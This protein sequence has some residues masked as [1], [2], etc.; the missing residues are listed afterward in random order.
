MT[1]SRPL[2]RAG[3]RARTLG[4]LDDRPS[5]HFLLLDPATPTMWRVPLS[6]D[7]NEILK[8]QFSKNG[9]SYFNIWHLVW[10]G[11]PI[12]LHQLLFNQQ[13]CCR[14]SS[15][16]KKDT[17]LNKYWFYKNR[18]IIWC[19]MILKLLIVKLK[20]KCQKISIWTYPSITAKGQLITEWNF[21][22][23]K[24]PKKQTWF[25]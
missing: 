19:F 9:H 5:W 6:P 11:L 12:L 7:K 2:D 8:F 20:L 4:R 25:L 14:S 10:F 21:C 15:K 22:V 16:T 23:F 24:S 17:S 18:I 13:T 1:A 3:R